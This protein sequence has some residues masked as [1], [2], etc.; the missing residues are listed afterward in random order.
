M[1]YN[2]IGKNMPA[3]KIRLSLDEKLYTQSGALLWMDR[4]IEMNS[5][6]QGGFLKSVG[7][8]FSGASLFLINYVCNAESAELCLGGAMPGTLLDFDLMNSSLICQKSSFLCAQPTVALDTIFN[9]RLSSS[10]FGGE[11]FILQK[12]SGSGKAFIQ[13]FGDLEKRE[14]SAGQELLVDTGHL[15]AFEESVSYEIEMLKGFKNI[16]FGGE[17]LFLAKLRGPGTVYL[18]TMTAK[19]L[20]GAIIPFIPIQRNGVNLNGSND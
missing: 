16:L 17:G 13:S 20:A 11:G 1:N 5:N 8:M 4:G 18:Q 7:R 10:F 2:I 12:L 3:V 6:M 15:V 9:K 19:D 14:L